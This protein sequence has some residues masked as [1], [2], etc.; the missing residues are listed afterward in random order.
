MVVVQSLDSEACMVSNQE[1]EASLREQARISESKSKERTRLGIIASVAAIA[2][3]TFEPVLASLAND[4]SGLFAA[5]GW[6]E[7]RAIVLT[8]TAI[9]KGLLGLIIP[10]IL[11]ILATISFFLKNKEERN[12]S[13]I[14]GMLQNQ[15]AERV[16]TND[17]DKNGKL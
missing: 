13:A 6:E 11:V 17:L 2:I 14:Q 5:A 15:E 16:Q 3:P 8:V 12:F 7:I 9:G 4:L 10:G 1:A